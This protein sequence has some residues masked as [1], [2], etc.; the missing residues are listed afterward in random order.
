ML[1]AAFKKF[2][3]R[4]TG[5]PLLPKVVPIRTLQARHRPLVLAHLLQ[6]S[7]A[8]RFLRF[9][10][11]ANDAQIERYVA[12][13][14]F[15]R[16]EIFGV[17]NR[18][19]QLIAMAH[20][21][22]GPTPQSGAEFGVSVIK[23]ARG[24]GLGARL[25]ARAGMHARNRNVKTMFIHALTQNSAMLKIAANAGARVIYHGTEAEAYL[26]LP[27][28]ALDTRLAQRLEQ[29]FAEADYFFKKHLLRG[30]APSQRG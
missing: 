20:L 5:R 29:R 1:F 18:R 13:L 19:L 6:L 25:F 7:D 2:F 3:L 17:F 9:G 27:A 15:E 4:L 12:K 26:Q 16:D 24:L 11:I 30:S 21:G 22:Y 14:D 8:D 10:Y 23:A 28:P